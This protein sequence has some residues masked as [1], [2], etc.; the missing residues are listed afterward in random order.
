MGHYNDS[1]EHE[2]EKREDE[3]KQALVDRI[4]DLN[5]SDIEMFHEFIDAIGDW[6][7]FYNLVKKD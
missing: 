1:Y 2:R 5:P 7:G 3:D 6:R 4:R